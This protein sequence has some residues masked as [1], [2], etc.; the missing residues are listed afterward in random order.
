LILRNHKNGALK[1]L[2]AIFLF[3]LIFLA[4]SYLGGED[5]GFKYFKN[6][7]YKAYDHLPQNWA[8]AQAPN[9][10]IYAANQGGVLEFDGVSWRII[11][12]P[13]YDTVRS[14]AIDQ[15]GTIFIGGKN[16]IGLLE[17]DKNGSLT[18][19][20]LLNHLSGD[21]KNFSNVWRTHAAKE[22]VY[23]RTSNYLFRW[24][25]NEM[26]VWEIPGFR[27]SFLCG[28]SLYV[29][30]ENKGLMKMQNNA[31]TLL[32]GGETFARE[33]IWMM[34]PYDTDSD[35]PRL[36]IGTRALGFFLFDGKTLKPFATTAG[37]YLNKHNLYNG[38]R[39]TRG[40]FALA[41]LT[42][43]LVIMA[44]DGRLKYVFDKNSG[45]QDDNVKYVF[46]DNRENLWLALNDGI[47]R[48]EYRS[49][50]FLYDDR[51]GL[52]GLVQ[53]VARRQGNLYAGTSSG[54]YVLRPHA[55]TFQP[56]PG[57]S[58]SC[59][60]LLPSGPSLLA[61]TNGGVVLVDEKNNTHSIL[62]DVSFVLTPSIK[63]PGRVWCGVDTGLLSLFVK[64]S[65]KTF[66]G[67]SGISRYRVNAVSKSIYSIAEDSNGTLWLVTASGG[68]LKVDFSNGLDQPAVTPY[69]IPDNPVNSNAVVA[70]HVIFA[71]KKG[72]F[73]FDKQ[74]DTLVP[75]YTLGK[76]FA[77]GSNPVFRIVQDKDKTIW[78]H[79]QSRNYH[80]VPQPGK[81]I[82][83]HFK[84]FRR[85]PICQVN[86]IQPDG[87]TTWFAGNDGL[88]R[89]DKTIKKDYSQTF[90]TLIRRVLI[91][92][93]QESERRIFN[94]CL[95]KPKTGNAGKPA[96]PVIEYSD[97]NL[98]F[99]FA[100]PFF[101][102][103]TETRYRCFLQGYDSNWSIWTDDTRKN[104]TNLD[105][106]LY[107]FRVQAQNIY[108]HHSEP[109]EFRFKI[110]PP[111][112]LT[113]WS[114][115]L[116]AAGFLFSMFLAAKWRSHKL[117]REK[118]KLEITIKERTKE[119]QDKNRQLKNQS[120]KLKEMDSIKSRFFANISHEFRTPLTLIMSPL[121]QML[122]DARLNEQKNKL[123]L[124]LRN[125]QRLLT[126]INQLLD[127]SRF[128]SG[129][130]KLQT[131]RQNIIPFLKGITSSFHMLAEQNHL[132]LEFQTQEQDLPLYFDA[133]K[134]E[135]AMINLLINA[136]KFTPA[137][138][139]ITI[140]VSKITSEMP[141]GD[142]PADFAEI[143]VRDTGIGI[144][145]D[146][147]AHIF[148]RFY[149][150]GNLAENAHKG[151]GIGLAL[152][153]EIVKLHKGKIDVHS[154]RGKGSEFVI[155]LP[156]GSAHLK[157]TEIA[158]L[159]QAALETK[160]RTIDLSSML[161]V[162]D[163]PLLPADNETG[164]T[165]CEE[166]EDL[167]NQVP[168]KD[169]ILIVEDN[170]DVRRYIRESLERH[171]TVIEAAD[172]K[173]GI[174]KAKQ[175]IPDL[176]VS[177]IMMPETNGYELCKTLKKD[178]NTSHI[179]IILLTAKASDESI[180]QG[181]ETGADD[182]VTKPFNTLILLSRI[183]NLI[184]LRRQLQLKIQRQKMLLPHEI[185]VS[186]T[187]EE[188]LKEFQA[189][190]EKNIDNPK[191]DIEALCKTLYMSRMSLFRKVQALTGETPKQ[192][193]LSYRLKRGAELL[194]KKSGN[195]TEVAMKVGFN[196]PPYFAKCFKEKYH[197]TPLS[198]QQSENQV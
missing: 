191:L 149:Q 126:L 51:T 129:K 192:F 132:K 24:D 52:P 111:W 184:D 193:I 46:E 6:Y 39:L 157:P 104:Y 145:R 121:E 57:I 44:H 13:G 58:A 162:H 120:D 5:S 56:I 153:R 190:I 117:D 92:E 26:K 123:N 65:A 19:K 152:T 73:R 86:A 54:L 108:H 131:A 171:Y 147:L 78:F 124:M 135:E 40:D 194:R 59:W 181:L 88:I 187:D 107:T 130:M 188:F 60:S 91:N 100:A 18:Y 177:D 29:Q 72:I 61:A 151:T 49:P 68:V 82:A 175:T 110:L 63:F 158:A 43:G 83:I 66:V 138:G 62:K 139:S 76:R 166:P 148:D 137:Q 99:E 144:A 160:N 118:Q 142:A 178:V 8:I 101:E 169:I 195:V 115:I 34:V 116:Y 128:D 42:G 10:I 38:I 122:T 3:G 67:P 55:K 11:G 32:P 182:Y 174:A 197:C 87:S 47:S 20:S 16:K 1:R 45:L 106:G 74:T 114:Y 31:L 80:A 23:S 71:S 179:P 81:D 183:K 7:N 198:Y 180:I 93:K 96:F 36:L 30:Q 141:D 70:G 173:Q 133:Q 103:E 146:Q 156:M 186:S 48:I 125:S 53:A 136:V 17:P 37:D 154:Q 189:V 97:R 14:I 119:I 161:D 75:D 28:G 35:S 89:Y 163:I 112:Y 9:G 134:I 155:Q 127:L 64:S 15:N 164:P 77:D 41:T 90:P 4:S 79:S 85:I 109:A 21:V 22:G 33:R 159:S 176:I 140:S 94:G 150:A 143:S 69:D 168:G 170:A 50:F 172:G 102:A 12:I 2:L 84:P 165:T 27:A 95:D 98:Y 196:S 105:P 167:E 113:W 25:S 185:S